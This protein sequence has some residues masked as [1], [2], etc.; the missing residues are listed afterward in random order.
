[1]VHADIVTVVIELKA[2][3]LL[4]HGRCGAGKEKY[5][6]GSRNG[7]SA[8]AKMIEWRKIIAMILAVIFVAMAFAI[9][10]PMVAHAKTKKVTPQV[11]LSKSSFTYNG[12]TQ[13]PKV[14]VKVNGKKLS[15]SKYNVSYP[16][17]SVNAGTYDV[18]VSL[19]NGYSGSKTVSY[20]I[21]PVKPKNVYAL[22]ESAELTY[23]GKTQK[24]NIEMVLAELPS[25][26][27]VRLSKSE[28]TAH[29]PSGKKIGTYKFKIKLKGNYTGSFTDAYEIRKHG[30]NEPHTSW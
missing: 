26:G 25:G 7:G 10:G 3:P 28:Y 24:A 23:N 2:G 19:K 16:R 13:K 12:K 27:S 1:M 9:Q 20:K 21:K 14:T 4:T 6:S 11:S 29:V 5:M 17:K 8:P 18:K 22:F 15:S 30:S